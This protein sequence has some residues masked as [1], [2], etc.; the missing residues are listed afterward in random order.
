MRACISGFSTDTGV[1]G[2][3][4]VFSAACWGLPRL[5]L[6]LQMIGSITT[7][8]QFENKFGH[9]KEIIRGLVVSVI[10]LLSTVHARIYA[11]LTLTKSMH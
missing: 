4:P 3:S 7:M 11:F 10:L 5:T 2:Q 1:S 9:M 6:A 8:E